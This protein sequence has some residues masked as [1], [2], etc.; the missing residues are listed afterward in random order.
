MAKDTRGDTDGTQEP[1]QN[2]TSELDEMTAVDPEQNLALIPITPVYVRKHVR[3]LS[4]IPCY[5]L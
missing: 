4:H 2:E 5:L 3:C 1:F